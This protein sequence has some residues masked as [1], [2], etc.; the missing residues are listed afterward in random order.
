MS[1]DLG[2]PEDRSDGKG[3]HPKVE[4]LFI[5]R[6]E[7]HEYVMDNRD[8]QDKNK[9]EIL[10]AL[11]QVVDDVKTDLNGDI[12]N[13]SGRVENLEADSKKQN[14]IAAAIAGAVGLI[15]AGITA[16]VAFARG[17]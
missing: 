10:D 8:R 11:G 16:A 12:D 17:G 3:P 7:F 15:T 14:L 5:T 9:S 1:N 6:R 2:Y 4:E 13:L